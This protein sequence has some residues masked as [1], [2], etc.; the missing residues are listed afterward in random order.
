MP[1]KAGD[2]PSKKISLYTLFTK[3]QTM[4]NKK[5]KNQTVFLK[6]SGEN[7]GLFSICGC[8]FSENP[9][10][11]ANNYYAVFVNL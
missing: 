7:W 5:N 11:N 1:C 10:Q 9:P 8:F 6:N 3:N 4:I 2:L